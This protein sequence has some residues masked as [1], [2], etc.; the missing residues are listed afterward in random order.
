[1]VKDK[2][3]ILLIGE[4]GHERAYAWKL[5]QS[6]RVELIFVRVRNVDTVRADDYEGL[7]KFAQENIIDLVALRPEAPLVAGIE[8]YFRDAKIPC[9]GPSKGAARIEG[10][11]T[12][13]KIFMTRHHI[14]T[15]A[16]RDFSSYE[17]AAE[18]VQTV[19]HKVAL[20]HMMKDKVFGDAGDSVVIEEFLVGQE[21]SVSLICDGKS[22]ALFPIAQDHKAAFDGDK[23]PN[24]GGMGC[25]ATTPQFSQ[26]DIENIR[27]NILEPTISGMQEEGLPFVGALCLNLMMTNEGAKV[28]EYN[29]R[30]SD[31]EAQAILPLLNTDLAGLMIAC[32]EGRLGEVK[33]ENKRQFCAVVIVASPGYPG[34]YPTGAEISMN[35][36]EDSTIIFHAGTVMKDRLRTSGGRVIAI[37]S[38]ADT[39]EDAVVKAYKGV[40]AVHFD[41]KYYRRDIAHRVLSTC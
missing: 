9:F 28:L 14:P 6:P 22:F 40:D 18:Y 24:T 2:L 20:R 38:T 41:G 27:E 29:A 32:T 3:R 7:V 21:L 37:A 10:S 12:W 39:L 16:Y 31:P 11:K 25:Y 33:I 4:G 1:M 15:A 26:A 8:G 36:V 13:A 35:A 30:F 17:E 5:N 34:T 23:G 19:D